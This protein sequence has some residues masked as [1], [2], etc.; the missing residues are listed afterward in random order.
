VEFAPEVAL[1]HELDMLEFVAPAAAPRRFPELLVLRHYSARL[2]ALVAFSAGSEAV[3]LSAMSDAEVLA[4]LMAQLRLMLGEALP[5]PVRFE[6]TSWDRDVFSCGSYSFLRPGATAAT[7][8]A[9]AEPIEGKLWLAGEHTRT[10]YPSTV[11]GAM[12][13]GRAAGAAVASALEADAAVV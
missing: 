1:P 9:L 2:N 3:A 4:A 7:R 8:A 10:D 13:S 6:R 12:L 5:A 11:H